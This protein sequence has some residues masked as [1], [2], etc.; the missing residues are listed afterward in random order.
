VARPG[1]HGDAMR[2][3]HPLER[4]RVSPA[5]P[6]GAGDRTGQGAGEVPPVAAAE[7]AFDDI[8]VPYLVHVAAAIDAAGGDV[9]PAAAAV[10]GEGHVHGLVGVG[11]PVGE[12][13]HRLGA[14]ALAPVVVG[15]YAEM[16]IDGR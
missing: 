11:D 8:V 1:I 4:R 6:L 5:A 7:G 3:A 9:H 2:F 14:F 10:V 13:Q 15:E 16:F 12:Q